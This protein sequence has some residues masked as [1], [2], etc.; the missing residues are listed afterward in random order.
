MLIKVSLSQQNVI[1]AD[2]T[3][4]FCKLHFFG[5]AFKSP[6]EFLSTQSWYGSFPFLTHRKRIISCM[7]KTSPIS[8]S[9]SPKSNKTLLLYRAL[10]TA[11]SCFRSP[12]L[13]TRI[14]EFV[15]LIEYS[16]CTK[17]K[18]KISR[19]QSFMSWS[20]VHWFQWKNTTI[21]EWVQFALFLAEIIFEQRCR[22]T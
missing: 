14:K 11:I 22:N 9:V 6:G 21:S 1:A 12:L 16:P 20:K 2:W 7:F 15:Y 4:A 8:M 13:H 17:T 10:W 18:K 5:T 3:E 19:K